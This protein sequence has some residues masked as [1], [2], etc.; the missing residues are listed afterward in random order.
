MNEKILN[1]IKAHYQNAIFFVLGVVFI[2]VFYV[3]FPDNPVIVKEY[4]DSLKLIHEY[5]LPKDLNNDSIRQEL[6]KK[7][8]NI[9][10]LNDYES[11]IKQKITSINDEV[12]KIPNLILTSVSNNLRFKGYLE[13]SSSAYFKAECPEINSGYIDIPIYFFNPEITTK[14]AFIK[15][16]ID[17]INNGSRTTELDYFYEIKN[18]DNFIRISNDLLKGVKYELQFGFMFKDE[19]NKKYPTFYSKKCTLLR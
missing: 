9:Q 11:Q 2:K 13:G 15:V 18:S 5:K 12:D 10:L 14:I 1:F 4:T 16:S 19:L 6:E 3:Y 8:K 17:R 7:V